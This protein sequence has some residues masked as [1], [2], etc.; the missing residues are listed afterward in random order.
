MITYKEIV[1]SFDGEDIMSVEQIL[2]WVVNTNTNLCHIYHYDRG[3]AQLKL[4]KTIEHPEN[5][6]RDIELTS[7]KPGHYKDSGASH[8]T[9]SQPTDPKE[10]KID[11][12]SREIAK[13]LEAGRTHHLYRDIIL[14]APPQMNGSIQHHLN[15][16]VKEFITH[17]IEK[18]VL[19]L[20]EQELLNLIHTNMK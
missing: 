20:K 13:E 17:I 2:T 14:I 18:D 16:H 7:D 1:D 9:F 12:F 10:I 6:L 19:F 11:Q 3:A 8:G 15:K 5:K 4:V